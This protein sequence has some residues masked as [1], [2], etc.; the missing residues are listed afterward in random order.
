VAA[1][2]DGTLDG[3]KVEP[4][5]SVPES[6]LVPSGRDGGFDGIKEPVRLKDAG[7]VDLAKACQSGRWSIGSLPPD[8]RPWFGDHS[9]RSAQIAA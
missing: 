4:A 5:D 1:A 9:R 6:K 3:A 7:A 8:G 2:N